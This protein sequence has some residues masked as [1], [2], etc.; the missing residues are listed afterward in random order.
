M[1]CFCVGQE[2]AQR[3]L[4]PS[5]LLLF[6][7]LDSSS[8]RASPLAPLPPSLPPQHTYTP[9]NLSPF[10]IYPP[11]SFLPFASS[12]SALLPRH[13]HAPN[14]IAFSSRRPS[15]RG[16]SLVPNLRGWVA[17]GHPPERFGA[18]SNTYQHTQTASASFLYKF[19]SAPAAKPKRGM[20]SLQEHVY[21]RRGPMRNFFTF[22]VRRTGNLCS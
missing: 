18:P 6:S 11:R 21:A 17:P 4:L 14:R 22:P 13:T 20:P 1:S 8:S 3:H 10:P 12:S 19:N 5:I 7:F 15:K 2:L 16:L 9:R